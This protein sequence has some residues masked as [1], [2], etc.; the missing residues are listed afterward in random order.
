MPNPLQVNDVGFPVPVACVDPN[1]NAYDLS[2]ASLLQATLVRPDASR[3][4]YS[5]GVPPSGGHLAF[6]TTGRDGNLNFLPASGDLFLAGLYRLQVYSVV[7]G[8]GL[9]QPVATF[10]VFPDL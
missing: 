4:V 2:G 3:V 7:A 8:T 10:R 9:Y 5:T 6:L 1:G